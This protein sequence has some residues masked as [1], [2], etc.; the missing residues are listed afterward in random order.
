MLVY[1][2]IVNGY[3]GGHPGSI[4]IMK[5]IICLK[6]VDPWDDLICLRLEHFFH[7][8]DI[9]FLTQFYRTMKVGIFCNIP[10]Y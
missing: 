2:K 9:I 5:I 7:K 4:F 3:F 6:D 8:K 1:Y 10:I